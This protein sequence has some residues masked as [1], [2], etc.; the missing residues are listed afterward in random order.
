[1]KQPNQTDVHNISDHNIIRPN[2]NSL[3]E[4]WIDKY[5]FGK[6]Q[7]G[8][9]RVE[10]W[11]RGEERETKVLKTIMRVK[12]GTEWEDDSWQVVAEIAME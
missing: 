7:I 6:Q 5:L 8:H 3:G 10:N 4:E 2:P 12:F 9:F 11:E 1:M